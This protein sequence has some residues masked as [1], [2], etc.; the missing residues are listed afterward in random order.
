MVSVQAR[1]SMNV[2]E[3]DDPGMDFLPSAMTGT[4]IGTEVLSLIGGRDG[5]ES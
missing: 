5:E 2:V 3:D 4:H 1:P